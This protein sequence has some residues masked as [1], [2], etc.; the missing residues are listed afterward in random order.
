MKSLATLRVGL[1]RL[2][3][4]NIMHVYIRIRIDSRFRYATAIDMKRDHSGRWAPQRI[5]IV[6]AQRTTFVC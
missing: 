2:R 3:V 4:Y 6:L 5:I 1:R